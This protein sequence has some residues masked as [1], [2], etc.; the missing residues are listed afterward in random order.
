M[1]DNQKKLL[2]LFIHSV[3]SDSLW[4]HRLQHA[5]LPCPSPSLRACSN[6][7]PLSRWC[8]PTILSAVI[9]FSF[10]QSFPASGSFL[11]SQLFTSG[12]QSIGGLAWASVL[13]NEYSGLISFKT[14][15]FDL[16]A[17]QGTLKNLLQHHSS[18]VSILWHSH[19]YMTT[20]RTIALT[21]QNFVSKVMALLFNMLSSLVI[22]FLPRTKHLWFHGCNAIRSD[23]GAQENKVCHCIHCFSIYLPWSDVTE[24]HDLR[25]LNAEF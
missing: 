10:L 2:L 22:A 18:K 7:C 6:S 21:I 4:P 17:V 8:H 9:P 5:R 23:F 14:N 16:F 3:V 20:G 12:G 1:E 25:F 24:C 15:W 19:P 11:M 13:P